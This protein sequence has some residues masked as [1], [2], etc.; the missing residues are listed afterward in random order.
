MQKACSTISESSCWTATHPPLLNT[1]IT[2]SLPPFLLFLSHHLLSLFHPL[3]PTNTF[4]SI[5]IIIISMAKDIPIST[6]IPKLRFAYY[7]LFI[8][9]VH[10]LFDKMLSDF[11]VCNS[12]LHQG[13]LVRGIWLTF[14]I[15]F[16]HWFYFNKLNWSCMVVI[17]PNFGFKSLYQNAHLL[18]TTFLY[19]RQGLKVR[20]SKSEP[21]KVMISGAPASGKGTQCE[22]IVQKASNILG[23]IDCSHYVYTFKILD[24]FFPSISV[25]C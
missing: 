9:N 7:L 20:C 21:L 25:S 5:I 15:Q 23:I 2:N 14:Q 10:I 12:P 4:R 16:G 3:P 11:P 17:S 22:M 8:F 6:S 13:F 24:F 1:I 19:V 18:S